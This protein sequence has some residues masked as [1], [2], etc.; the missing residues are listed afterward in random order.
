MKP[1]LS[2]VAAAR[3]DDHGGDLLR[4]MQLFVNCLDALCERHGL[5]AE[6]V[7]VEWN[8]PAERPPL[9]E[10]LEWASGP[11]ACGVRI[12][13]VPPG[14]HQRFKHGDGLPLFQMIA[15]N[16]GVRRARGEYVLATNVDVVFSDELVSFLASGRLRE[17][18]LYRVERYDVAAMPS[19]LPSALPSE[20]GSIDELLAWCAR[21]VVRISA[22][23]ATLDLRTGERHT[24]YVPRTR[25]AHL[26]TNA[27]GDFQLMAARHWR[28]L[29]GYAEFETY[30][31]HLDSLLSYAAHF[32]GV[33][34]EVLADPMRVYHF[35]HAGGWTP[36]EKRSRTLETRLRKAGVP[37][38][39]HATFDA[40]ALEMTRSGRPIIFNDED[41][42]LASDV[43][44]E[45]SLV[46]GFW[47]AAPTAA[48]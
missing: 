23:D 48:L 45:E 34:E 24:I 38:L 10:A 39:E 9:S 20:A 6:L 3:N 42:G 26:H 33:R 27:C 7:L 21:D 36:G 37:Q 13:T 18:R 16:A 30:S 4:R 15:K 14:V 31:M 25:R 35:E 19:A 2:V 46:F 22:R 17:G 41:W 32:S 1:L 28:E 43:L 11:R 12:V 40:W 29:R 8:P 47:E 5:A 44:T